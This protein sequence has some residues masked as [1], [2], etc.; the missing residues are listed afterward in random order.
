VIV[1]TGGT[2]D[3][4]H[5]GHTDFLRVCKKVAGSDGR[6]VVSLNLDDFVA[7]YK[8]KA[9]ICPFDERRDVLLGCR[10]VDEVIPNHGGADS[11][12]AIEAATPDFILIG[13]DWA[14]R[15]YYKQMD[16]TPEWLDERGITLLYVPR[17]RVLSST[18][19]KARING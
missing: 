1:Y 18:A 5:A 11:K 15:D 3:L 6:V 17:L 19:I 12:P 14:H 2:F 9:P 7:V 13:D 10:Y 4:L 16:F 8:H